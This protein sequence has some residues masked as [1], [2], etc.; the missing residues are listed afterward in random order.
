MRE[1]HLGP[2]YTSFRMVRLFPPPDYGLWS[3]AK[4]TPSTGGLVVQAG[5]NGP[6]GIPEG[7][8]SGAAYEYDITAAKS[9]YYT[10]RF[11]VNIGP[12]SL[13][14]RGEIFEQN[15][16]DATILMQ[17]KN[18]PGAEARFSV[19]AGT[20]SGFVGR[21]FGTRMFSF[22]ARLTQGAK[23]TLEMHQLLSFDY[24]PGVPSPAPY[25]EII[26]T[27]SET[28]EVAPDLPVAQAAA[29]PAVRDIAKSLSRLQRQV[30]EATD[31]EMARVGTFELK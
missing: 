13:L 27:Y 31:E 20:G 6:L 4:F 28:V 17:L 14:P 9:D 2:P 26:A 21:N 11:L 12:I 29:Q 1:I 25:G 19:H 7:V 18:V 8:D 22:T 15:Q 10:F 3:V 5:V 16:I 30:V 24:G 23:Y